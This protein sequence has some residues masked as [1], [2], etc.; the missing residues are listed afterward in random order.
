MRR[1]VTVVQLDGTLPNLAL[2]LNAVD[3]YAWDASALVYA[4]LIFEK[5]RPVAERLLQLVPHASIGGTGWDIQSSLEAIGINT[6]ALAYDLYPAFRSSI[7][8]TQRG[9]RL[10]CPFCVVPAKE[11]A[12]TE[13]QSIAQIWRGEPWPR[14]VILLDNDF[15]GQPAWRDR[16]DELIDGRFKVCLTQGINARMLTDETAAALA[17]LDYREAKMVRKRLY[18]AW[19][20]RRDEERLFTGLE[21][22]QA[23]GVKP[24]HIMVYML[25][26]YWPGETVEDWL[27]RQRK[28]RA[29]GCRPYPMPYRRTPAT[30]GFQRWVVGGVDVLVPPK[31]GAVELCTRCASAMGLAH[32]EEG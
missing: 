31:A 30:V 9:C 24:D 28:L 15:F 7:G 5:T 23:H 26:G 8:F 10:R 16:V 17:S 13:A 3:Q 1:V 6:P 25:I 12:V 11:G 18:T 19:D 4:N 32:A 27:Y 21:R 29:F 14:E 2:T 20:N 22:L